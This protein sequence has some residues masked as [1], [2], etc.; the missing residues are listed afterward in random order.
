MS[1]SNLRIRGA[2]FI[3]NCA[4]SVSS[5]RGVR[6]DGSADFEDSVCAILLVVKAD[7][8]SVL[9]C[10]SCTRHKVVCAHLS[11]DEA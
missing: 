5:S 2:S 9:D 7:N 10:K 1:D 6:S 11:N 8:L 4:R 3:K